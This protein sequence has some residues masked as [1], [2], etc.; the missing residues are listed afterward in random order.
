M[1]RIT[2]Y[3]RPGSVEEA[4]G[5]RQDR[6]SRAFFLAG[7][8]DV[9]VFTPEGATTAIDIMHLGLDSIRQAGGHIEIGATA[10]LRDIERH[11]LLQDVA[12]GAFREAVRETG[13]WLIRNA[14]TLTGNVCN[15]SPSADSAPM[16]LALDASA[17]LSD[18]QAIPLDQFFAGPHR[19]VLSGRL[20][21][22]IRIEP[23]GRS[24]HFQKLSRS[25][26]D[27]AQVSLAVTARIEGDLLRDVRIAFGSVAPTPVRARKAESLLEGRSPSPHQIEQAVTAARTEITPIDD[28]RTS[29][30]YR[31]H[32]AGVILARGLAQFVT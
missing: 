2:E 11:T 29:A 13:P 32:A 1:S 4:L 27:I 5:A 19:T 12:G 23:R 26:S 6:G 30:S 22:A 14:A 20:V 18:G 9:L 24:G 8:T 16:L 31:R 25:K 10:V 15:A 17:L 21:T 7:G 3:L 28:W